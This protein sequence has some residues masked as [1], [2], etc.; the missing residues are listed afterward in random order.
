ML[1]NIW[2]IKIIFKII[3][4]RLPIKYKI[5]KKFGLFLHGKMND[6]KYIE[7]LKSEMY[8]TSRKYMFI[9][10]HVYMFHL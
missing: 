7:I 6:P 8:I 3:F 10:Y 4:S 5:W 1:K 2:W 9:P